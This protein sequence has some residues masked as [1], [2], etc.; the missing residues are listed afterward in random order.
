MGKGPPAVRS[1]AGSAGKAETSVASHRHRRRQSLSKA[2]TEKD[3]DTDGRTQASMRPGNRVNTAVLLLFMLVCI[4]KTKSAI[5]QD[6][7]FLQMYEM[8]EAQ[9][10]CTF[11][12]LVNY[13]NWC[14]PGSNGRQPVDDVDMLS[15][16]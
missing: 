9:T 10:N 16:T 13:G 5:L 8:L 1:E 7:N 3:T 6:R 12:S 11:L 15:G 4:M 2:D 14:G